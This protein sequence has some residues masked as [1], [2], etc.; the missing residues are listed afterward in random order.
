MKPKY[1]L[2]TLGSLLL[3]LEGACL[4]S[5]SPAEAQDAGKT[6][7]EDYHIGE[8]Q[9][10]PPTPPPAD[11][12]KTPAAPTTR[13]ARIEY[14]TGNVTWR[15]DDKA[16]WKKAKA[17]V[18][19][20]QGAQ[21]WAVDDGRAE[22]RFED[23]SLLRLGK[24][25]VATLDTFYTDAQGSFTRIK[26][27]SGQAMLVL[28]KEKSVYQVDAAPVTVVANGWARVRIGSG[29]TV[30]VGVY[31]G[32]AV[33]DGKMGKQ[34][35]KAGD[36]VSVADSD[37]TY[38][39]RSLP[40]AD[41]WDRWNASRDRMLAGDAYPRPYYAYP[42]P[43]YG[44]YVSLWFGSDFYFGHPHHFFGGDRGVRGFRR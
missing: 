13:L 22:I 29:D 20:R 12:K 19:L 1:S 24:G 40:P 5:A 3:A 8:T 27:S 37:K 42:Y 17:N 7:P 18:G 41:S 10:A 9:K 28:T 6:P 34:T 21:I 38:A 26:M 39:V 44:P 14:V 11:T 32:Q 35:L 23:G 25:A 2:L 36:Y 43:A 16:D 30:N 31:A 33:V 4:W 15:P